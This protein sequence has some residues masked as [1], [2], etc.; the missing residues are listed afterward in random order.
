MAEILGSARESPRNAENIRTYGASSLKELTVAATDPQ[1]DFERI[2]AI[3]QAR[4]N[5]L[6]VKNNSSSIFG[7][8]NNSGYGEG[9]GNWIPFDTGTADQEET[10]ASVRVDLPINTIGG[11]CWKFAAVMGS[12]SPR[13]K[14]VA[15]D[16]RN[17]DDIN[18]AH[19]ADVNIRDL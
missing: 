9:Q 10:G 11:D 3:S 4:Y 16:L 13:V 2:T 18:A 6:L 12:S 19:C 1:F 14:G 15:D 5:W 7:Y 8:D 17:P